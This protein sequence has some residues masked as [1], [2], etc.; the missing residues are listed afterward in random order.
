MFIRQFQDDSGI[1]KK[2]FD[3]VIIG[4]EYVYGNDLNSFPDPSVIVEEMSSLGPAIQN[5]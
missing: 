1:R 5:S 3:N 2:L 4:S